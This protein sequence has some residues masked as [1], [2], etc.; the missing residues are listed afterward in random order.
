MKLAPTAVLGLL[1][2]ASLY[3]GR[4]EARCEIANDSGLVYI[5]NPAVVVDADLPNNAVFRTVQT[6]YGQGS[7]FLKCD[8]DHVVDI[9]SQVI[10]NNAPSNNSI[11]ELRLTD[12]TPTG[13]GFRFRFTDN[14]GTASD[15]PYQRQVTLLRT[16]EAA[17][18]RSRVQVEYV[19]L[20]D[21]IRYGQVEDNAYLA[22]TRVTTAGVFPPGEINTLRRVRT[23]A[24]TLVAPTC[25][26]DAGSLNQEVP[27]G[28]Y[29]VSELQNLTETPWV[30]FRLT[31][32]ACANPNERFADIAFGQATDADANN[33]NLFSMNQGGPAGLGI[34]IQAGGGA[35]LAMTPGESR[36]FSVLQTGQSYEFQAR[37][38]RT[39]G[40]VAPGNIDRPVRVLVT[41]R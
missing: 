17:V 37:L 36:E 25:S 18:W 5:E 19:K 9:E 26:I 7:P 22:R 4:A 41:F 40:N 3:G 14:D 8:Q 31:M 28:D 10:E 21:D 29:S 11:R 6:E 33:P 30:P 39:V 38:E 27:L 24:L 15:V 32:S 16:E 20:R 34:A 35:N 2:A 23:R 12:G 1:V 13:V